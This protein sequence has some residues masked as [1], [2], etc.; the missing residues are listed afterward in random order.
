MLLS[1]HGTLQKSSCEHF[2]RSS[3]YEIGGEVFSLAEIAN[4]VIR[5]NMNH[6]EK[7]KP[8]F[9]TA[10][11]KSSSYHYYA[12][13]YKTRLTH[14]VLNTGIT[15]CPRRVP[16]FRPENLDE[17]LRL[18]ASEFLW[19]NLGFDLSK[20]IILLPKVCDT[21]RA[22]FTNETAQAAYATLQYC[23]PYL[24]EETRRVIVSLLEDEASLTFK[25]QSSPDQY[26][27]T[28]QLFTPD[29][30]HLLREFP[31]RLSLD[32]PQDSMEA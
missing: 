16:V 4:C 26:Y 13:T 12:L 1:V 30:Q 15:T 21:Y 2:M 22:D 25:Y 7:A 29:A 20:K 10:P 17:T 28:L 32:G 19:R 3:C 9:V 31:D 23:L 11:K 14:F 6:P 27:T 24:R 18:Q 8:P 5:G